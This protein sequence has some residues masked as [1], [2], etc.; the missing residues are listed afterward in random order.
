P[1][2]FTQTGSERMRI[3]TNGFVGIG[4]SN[5][6]YL[7]DVAGNI[8]NGG[9]DFV[10]GS[11][12][13]VSRGNSGASRALVKDSSATL[14]LNYAGDFTGGA[15][16]DSDLAF[17]VSGDGLKYR[18]A[19]GS[20]LSDWSL[21]E[22]DDCSST[23]GWSSTTGALSV[24]TTSTGEYWLTTGTYGTRATQ[25]ISKTYTIPAHTRVKVVANIFALDTWDGNEF[26]SVSVGGVSMGSAPLWLDGPSPVSYGGSSAADNWTSITAVFASTDTT[27]TLTFDTNSGE[28]DLGDESF[29]PSYVEIYVK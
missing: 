19:G 28:T 8:R 21:V 3:H 18:S 2:I 25:T 29:A 23:S 17:N 22:V 11:R 27:L 24:A 6:T 10:L 12:D 5:P 16:V 14:V 13:Q 7:L 4:T 9:Y 26:V 15:R 20:Y 1:I